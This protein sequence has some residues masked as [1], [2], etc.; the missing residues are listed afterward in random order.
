MMD[1]KATPI[2]KPSK[3][4]K[5]TLRLMILTG[6]FTM[7]F[8]LTALIKPENRGDGLLYVLLMIT[9]LYNCLKYLHEWYHYFSIDVPAAKTATRSYTVDI[10]TTFCPGEP[11]DMLERTLTAIQKIH[12]PHTAWCCDEAN[13]PV[14]RS[15]CEK[16]G[17]RHVTRNNRLHAKAGNINNALQY[18]TGDLCVIL[19]PDHIPAPGLLDDIVPQFDDPAVGFVQIVQAYYNHSENLVAKGAA[20]QTYQFYGPMMMSMHAYGTVQA[21]GANCTFRRAALDSIGGHAPGLAEDMNTAMQLH[22]HGWKSVYLPVV[23]TRGL[24]PATL[25]SYYKQQLKWSRGT[26]ELLVTTY[27][28]YFFRFTGR[29]KLHYGTLP[30]HY[31]CGLI[32]LINWLIPVISLYTGAIPLHFD[33]VGFLLASLPFF[34]MTILIRHY[35]QKWVA[36]ETERGFHV[37]GGLL[38]IGTWWIHCTGLVYTLLRKKVPYIPTPKND[39]DPTPLKLHIPNIIVVVVSLSAIVYG[40]WY[41]M[42]PFTLFMAGLAGLNIFFM[43]FVFYAAAGSRHTTQTLTIRKE[44][45]RRFWLLRHKVYAGV[46]K[47][48]LA[49]SVIVMTASAITY[50]QLQQLP[51]YLPG[52]MPG[53]EVFYSGIFLPGNNNGLTSV[54]R[55]DVSNTPIVSFYIPWGAALP[56][57]SLEQVYRSGGIPMI[58]WEPW[59][60][61][62]NDDSIASF[63][64]RIALLDK[65]LFLRFAHEPENTRYPWSHYTP[66]AYVANWKHVHEL[67]DRAGASQVIWVWNPWKPA[68]THFP[69]KDYVDWLGVNVLD[70]YEGDTSRSFE[71]IYRPFHNLSLF[72]SGL[73]VMITEAGSLSPAREDWF[74]AAQQAIDTAFP[75]VKAMIVFNNQYDHYHPGGYRNEPLNWMVNT[76]NIILSDQSVQLPAPLPP[77]QATLPARELP[78]TLHAVVYDKGVHWFR[79]RHTLLRKELNKDLATMRS[80]SVKTVVRTL[81]G[82]YDHTLLRLTK[83]YNMQIIGRLWMSTLPGYVTDSLQ[84]QKEKK[85]LLDVVKKYRHEKNIIAWNLGQDVLYG[86]SKRYYKPDYYY[87]QNNYLAWLMDFCREIRAIDPVRPITMDVFWDREGKKRLNL[88]ST[89]LPEVDSYSLIA[90]SSNSRLL[91]EPIPSNARWG[92]VPVAMWHRLPGQKAVT[93]PAWQDIENMDFVSLNGVLDLQGRQKP[94]YD[95][96]AKYWVSSKIDAPVLPDIKILKPA[97]ITYRDKELKYHALVRDGHG[98]AFFDSLQYPG[99]RFEWYLIRTDDYGTTLYMKKVGEGDLI[100]LTIPEDPEHYRLYLEAVAGNRVKETASTLNIPLD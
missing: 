52:P 54:Q 45:K 38:Q 42:N 58:T 26:F 92:R 13:D 65:P 89:S 81:P 18:A 40:L 93:I 39:T 50:R 25:S 14:V 88:Y 33:I 27:L 62:Y 44:I 47:Y 68:T 3:G 97:K 84:M 83:Q 31:L 96:V 28:K 8:F 46:R 12:Y 60:V 61:A 19:D 51:A 48:A 90:D 29:Q 30:F 76:E 77:A 9:I 23:L 82:I 53:H 15:L 34:A 1:Y 91:Q 21:I 94:G 22:G 24:V 36:E 63:A 74:E 55:V 10:F 2:Q 49:L 41:D 35:V 43:L 69:G 64:A 86:L 66:E 75:E 100:E 6:V 78:N 11:Y 67:F 70:Y 16:L 32:F 56:V 79:N 7:G 59:P 98:W 71:L 4:E 20:Q 37:V 99:V 5:R 95:T 73:P 72:Q 17:V 57:D 85:R 80:L 87:H